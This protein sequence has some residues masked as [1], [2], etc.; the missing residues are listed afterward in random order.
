MRG[1]STDGSVE[2]MYE[3]HVFVQEAAVGELREAERWPTGLEEATVRL[4]TVEWQASLFAAGEP[5][6]D[7]SMQGVR[8]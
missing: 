6:F 5:G 1:P 2:H 3:E 8:R 4:D 7:P